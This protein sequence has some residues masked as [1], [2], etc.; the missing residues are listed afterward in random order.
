[1]DSAK[2]TTTFNNKTIVKGEL[3]MD[4]FITL[5]LDNVVTRISRKKKYVSEFTRKTNTCSTLNT[6]MDP[7]SKGRK[8]L[9]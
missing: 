2:I 9:H 8:L 5:P 7:K 4:G 6:T 3:C 1:M